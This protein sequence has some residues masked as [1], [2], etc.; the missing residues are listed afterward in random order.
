[1]RMSL[2]FV[3]VQVNRTS[4]LRFTVLTQKIYIEYSHKSQDL[5]LFISRGDYTWV[6][7]VYVYCIPHTTML[8]ARCTR[9]CT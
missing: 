2:Q 8:V 5:F 6:P 4:Y 3:H 7:G 9:V 1:M